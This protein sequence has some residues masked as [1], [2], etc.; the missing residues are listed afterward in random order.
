MEATIKFDLPEEHAD[1]LCAIH[2]SELAGILWEITQ[3]LRKKYLKY[4]DLTPEQ[5][6]IAE[7]IFDDIAEQI[8]FNIDDLVQ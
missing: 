1:L 8:D 7:K 2:G 3:N 5:D 6:K 4:G